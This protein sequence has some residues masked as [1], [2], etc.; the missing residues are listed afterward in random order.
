MT[1]TKIA[2]AET[3]TAA[4]RPLSRDR[5]LRAAVALAD[6]EGIK[7]VTMRR[8]AQALGVE[9]MTLYYHVANKAALFDGIAE[10]VTAE[11]DLPEAAGDWRAD[12]RHIAT[13]AYEVYLRHPWAPNLVLTT[14]AGDARMR[15]MN[16][17]LGALRRAGFTAA[18]TDHAY[19]AVESH[20]MGFT[21]WEVGMDLGPPE[22]L[23]AMATAFVEQLDTESFPFV[24]EH[25]GEHLRPDRSEEEG[26]F[27]Y[28]LD[29]ILD[30]LERKLAAG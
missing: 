5:V 26:D 12:I 20:I 1:G 7:A 17:L 27:A 15:Y 24:A 18:E 25:V 16:A 2:A 30:G 28:G 11:V 14:R 19:H 9:A 29:L 23:R 10:L 8:L 13:S 6:T 4:R 22:Q 3:V 21:L